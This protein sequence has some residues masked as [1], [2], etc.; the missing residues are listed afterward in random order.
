MLFAVLKRHVSWLSALL[1][2]FVNRCSLFL[3][4]IAAIAIDG[5][6]LL[7]ME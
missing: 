5:I 7:Q 2:V 3:D 4:R 6:L 1:D